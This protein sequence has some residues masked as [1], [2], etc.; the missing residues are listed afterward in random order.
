MTI[1]T[2]F[3]IGDRVVIPDLENTKSTIT[4][5]CVSKL[6]VTYEVHWFH[7]G[8][9]KDGWLTESELTRAREL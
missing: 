1:D 4:Q 2:K 9:R 5:I 7:N 6:G 8:E 3:S